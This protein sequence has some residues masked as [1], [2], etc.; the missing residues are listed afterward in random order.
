MKRLLI[1]AFVLFAF[2][3]TAG[4]Q[5]SDFM[6]GL[7]KMPPLPDWQRQAFDQAIDKAFRP[8]CSCLVFLNKKGGVIR[9]PWNLAISDDSERRLV[10]AGIYHGVLI[11]LGPKGEGS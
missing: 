5:R 3:A 4:E 8:R 9:W 6:K 1:L 2:P 7:D 10:W 11:P